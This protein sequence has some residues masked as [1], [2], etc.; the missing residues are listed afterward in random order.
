VVPA[1]YDH[2]RI[3]NLM[4]DPLPPA[5]PKQSI[6]DTPAPRRRGSKAL[7]VTIA[8]LGMA[9]L[10]LLYAGGSF[11]RHLIAYGLNATECWTQPMSDGHKIVCGEEAK[12]MKEA[13]KEAKKEA[14]KRASRERVTKDPVV[15]SD[16]AIPD[17]DY[18]GTPDY[19]DPAP[20][21]PN[22]A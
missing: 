19:T 15:P 11:D 18:D 2:K 6:A 12:V 1:C 22:R 7:K 20:E 5:A 10:G 21:N 17:S 16:R 9:L 8:V 4:Q 3:T 14:K 13:A